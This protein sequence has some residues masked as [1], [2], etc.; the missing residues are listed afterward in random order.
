MNYIHASNEAS[1]TP[2]KINYCDYGTGKPV[3][4]ISGWPFGKEMWEYQINDLVDSGHRVIAYDRRGFGKSSQPWDGYDYDTLT[5]DLKAMIDQLELE[6][7]TL[8]GFSMGGGEVVRYFS[9]HGGRRVSKAVLISAVT[10][11]LLETESN[12]GGVA[13]EVFD[14]I[15]EQMKQDR[16]GFLDEFGKTF[17]GISILNKPLSAPLL[18]YYRMLCAVASPRA[19]SECVKA[20]SNTDFRSEMQLVTVPTLIIHGSDDKTVPIG[21]TGKQSA[22]LIPNNNL[23]IYDGAPHGLFYTEREKLNADLLNFLLSDETESHQNGHRIK[24]SSLN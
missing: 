2:V 1:G 15:A 7:I 8:I 14:K 12:P 24:T 21:P 19:T 9:R 22:K 10:P 5:D 18:E 20:F 23:I 6:D 17:F 16:I 13:Q 4:L 11:Y 3:I